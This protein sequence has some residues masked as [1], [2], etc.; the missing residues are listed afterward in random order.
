[1]KQTNINDFKLMELLA[2][3]AYYIEDKGSKRQDINGELITKQR[4]AQKWID[5]AGL[6]RVAKESFSVL[7]QHGVFIYM[8]MKNKNLY[9]CCQGTK[10][11]KTLLADMSPGGPGFEIIQ[12]Y[13]SSIQKVLLEYT[14]YGG[15][16]EF[17]NIY[18]AG[19]SLGGALV[20]ILSSQILELIASKRLQANGFTAATFQSPGVD[21]CID[22]SLQ[23]SL[24]VIRD[25]NILPRK[26]LRFMIFDREGDIISLLGKHAFGSAGLKNRATA[27]VLRKFGP[28]PLGCIEAHKDRFFAGRIGDE[29]HDLPISLENGSQQSELADFESEME[30]IDKE[31][32]VRDYCA[33]DI[34]PGTVYFDFR[35]IPYLICKVG[36]FLGEQFCGSLSALPVT[37]EEAQTTYT[38]PNMMIESEKAK[39]TIYYQN[40]VFKG[41][42]EKPFDKSS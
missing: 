20:Q 33:Q 5:K 38:P 39:I 34:M 19:H 35:A 31:E 27:M 3:F 4:L 30:I 11:D 1:M 17:N 14:N 23:K 6:K 10:C 13:K 18:I 7:E 42:E 24:D 2:R 8:F 21:F 41:G 12:A 40:P 16:C 22:Y 29:C 37:L 36:V 32:A 15:D 28:K 9:I 25:S 26:S